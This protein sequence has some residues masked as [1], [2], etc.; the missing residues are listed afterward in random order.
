MENVDSFADKIR[1]NLVD[2]KPN[3]LYRVEILKPNG[4]KRPIGRSMA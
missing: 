1:K 3:T 2:Y 4:K